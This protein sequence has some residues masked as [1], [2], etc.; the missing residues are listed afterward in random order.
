MASRKVTLI[1]WNG[2]RDTVVAA[3]DYFVKHFLTVIIIHNYRRTL[4]AVG[5][6]IVLK[7]Y[8]LCWPFLVS[9]TANTIFV[10]PSSLP[11]ASIRIQH[12]EEDQNNAVAADPSWIQRKKSK[13]ADPSSCHELNPHGYS[14]SSSHTP[15]NIS[16]SKNDCLNQKPPPLTR[17]RI[18][19]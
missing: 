14:P 10:A 8:N 6:S 18:Q 11:I 4:L 17:L 19:L 13:A 15:R 9:F 5:L 16:L 3:L 2:R 1:L 12:A 7:L